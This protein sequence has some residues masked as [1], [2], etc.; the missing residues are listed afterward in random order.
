MDITDKKVLDKFR[1]LLSEKLEVNRLI[2]F[3]SRSRGD[4]DPDSD[5]DVLVVLDERNKT[6]EDYVADCAWEAGIEYGIVVCPTTFSTE[7]WKNGPQR[8]SL[9][10]IAIRE[11]GVPA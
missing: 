6:V 2:L 3:G 1:S 9:L 4:F 7:E 10:A 11:E 8:Y 5:M